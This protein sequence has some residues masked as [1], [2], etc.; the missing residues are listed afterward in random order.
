MVQ[1]FQ[2]RTLVLSFIYFI[3][4]RIIFRILEIIVPVKS[5]LI[6][7]GSGFNRFSDNPKYLFLYFVENGRYCPIWISSNREE[8]KKLKAKG[9]NCSYKWGI[10]TLFLVVRAKYFIISHNVKDV[11]PVIPQRGIIINL[12]HGTPIKKIGLDSR[13]EKEWIENMVRSG[14]T[15]PYERWDYFVTATDYTSSIFKSAM[16]L[17][18]FKLKPLGQ[19]RTDSLYKASIDDKIKTDIEEGLINSDLL[20]GKKKILYAPTF[21]NNATSDSV[22]MESLIKIDNAIGKNS[23]TVVL[24]KPHPLNKIK[25]QGDLFSKRSNIIDVSDEDTQELLCVIDILITDYSSI[26]FD[27]MIT[28]KP[29]IS[30][31]FDIEE[32]LMENG[33]LYF[34]F[35]ELG[36][37]VVNNPDELVSSIFNIDSLLIDYDVLKFNTVFSCNEIDNFI[38]VL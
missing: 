16:N 4:E 35:R 3:V 37:I 21:R 1:K 9:Y 8:V 15:L 24:F 20:K 33:E 36:T 11:F 28:Q 38:K 23:G 30:Y 18:S 14:R 7:F 10:K 29:I 26:M 32:Y 19:P 31:I 27:F 34:S 6:L 2:I 12:W 25:F 17:P 13:I 22:I 5:D